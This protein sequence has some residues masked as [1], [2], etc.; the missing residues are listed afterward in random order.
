M[1]VCRIKAKSHDSKVF[2]NVSKSIRDGLTVQISANA[3]GRMRGIPIAW[4]IQEPKGYMSSFSVPMN[5]GALLYP[6]SFSKE[7]VVELL[8]GDGN[9]Q[10]STAEANQQPSTTGTN[11]QPGTTSQGAS[12]SA[13]STPVQRGEGVAFWSPSIATTFSANILDKPC[14][15]TTFES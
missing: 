1:D 9:Q 13:I 2:R 12:S 11:S 5:S 15:S 7:Q 4:N 3:S 14:T 10:P 6:E 8:G